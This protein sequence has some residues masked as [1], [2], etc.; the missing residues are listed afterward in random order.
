MVALL[1]HRQLHSLL[2]PAHV[3]DWGLDRFFSKMVPLKGNDDWMLNPDF[4]VS[5]VDGYYEIKADLP[6]VDKDDLDISIKGN[7]LTVKGERRDE[8][9]EEE[10]NFHHVERRFGSF[11]RSFSLPG[12]V[13]ADA[14]EATYKDGVLT[15]KLPKAEPV[16]PSRVDVEVP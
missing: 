3:E 5:D 2:C 6:G 4:D 15:M 13:D 8:R 11:C 14:V 16:K 1:P 9:K 12:E 7:V 10:K